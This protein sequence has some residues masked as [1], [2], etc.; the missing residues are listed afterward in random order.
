[1]LETMMNGGGDAV[2]G[3]DRVNWEA[4]LEIKLYQVDLEVIDQMG[5]LKGAETL[6]I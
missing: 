5:G 2:R 6:I 1:M 4:Y 3:S